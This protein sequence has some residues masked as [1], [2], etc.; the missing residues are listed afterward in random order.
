MTG[1]LQDHGLYLGKVIESAPHNAKGNKE[2]SATWQ[3][4][5]LALLKSGGVWD[6]PPVKL[7]WDSE[8]AGLRD[9]FISTFPENRVWGFKDPRCLLCLPLWLAALPE[10]KLCGTF[11]HPYLVAQSLAKRNNYSHDESYILWEH[12]NTLLLNYAKKRNFPLIC[13]DWDSSRY[14]QAVLEIALYL[15][16][17]ENI[18]NSNAFFDDSLRSK[19]SD[20]EEFVNTPE[21]YMRLYERL[22]DTARENALTLFNSI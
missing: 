20:E 1:S 13:F 22:Q 3:I 21:K 19:K 4:N 8:V 17:K 5:D 9:S 16:L 15:G 6:K 7:T 2:N 14:R 12:Y 18:I 11:R 10:M